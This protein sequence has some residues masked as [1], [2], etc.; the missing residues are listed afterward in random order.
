MRGLESACTPTLASTVAACPGC[1]NAATMSSAPRTAHGW[2]AATWAPWPRRS[3]RSSRCVRRGYMGGGPTPPP[4]RCSTSG[5]SPTGTRRSLPPSSSCSLRA[6]GVPR[7]RISSARAGRCGSPLGDRAAGKLRRRRP[8]VDAGRLRRPR[9]GDRGHAG[10]GRKAAASLRVG[11][12]VARRRLTVQARG[13]PFRDG[14]DVDHQGRSA[15]SAELA[16]RRPGGRAQPSGG[17][18]DRYP[19][20]KESR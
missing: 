9:A 8:L 18:P 4:A 17:S 12:P 1:C 16:R 6:A 20:V 3:R 11:R 19:T 10:A 7:L 13:L 5:C 14:H 15:P 2:R